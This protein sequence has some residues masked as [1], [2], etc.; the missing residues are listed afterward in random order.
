VAV[1]ASGDPNE[2]SYKSIYG[3][4]DSAL[5][6]RVRAEAYGEDIGQHSW[7]TA[8]D[9]RADIDRLAL[10]P[11]HHLLDVGCGPCGP[12]TY[13]LDAVRC[14]GTGL[15]L[16]DEA[17]AAGR[18]RATSLGLESLATIEQADLNAPLPLESRA[19]D[20][21]MSLDVVLHV[22]DRTALFREIA[23]VLVP[24]ARFLFTDAAVLVGAISDEE[25]AARSLHGHC[26]F[27][28]P[29]FNERALGDAGFRLLE[30]EDRTESLLANAGGRL[31]ARR[32]H[33]QDLEAVEGA[34]GFAREQ[35]YLETV[36]GLARRRSLS[37]LMYLAELHGG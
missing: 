22:R 6:R 2:R 26:R 23:R 14:R 4:F 8:H 35:Q 32:A 34:A 24:G 33:H 11:A 17:V 29:G 1:T 19:F 36:V 21:A 30:T 16:S 5:M 20:A 31:A 7:V 3:E 28:A 25:V 15:D 10:M 13:V 27:V 37:R 12:L 18:R 9:L